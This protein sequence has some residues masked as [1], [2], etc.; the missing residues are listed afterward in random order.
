VIGKGP[1]NQAWLCCLN[2]VADLQ[3]TQHLPPEPDGAG[4][5]VNRFE[6]PAAGVL[7]QEQLHRAPRDTSAACVHPSPWRDLK[8][9]QAAFE[10]ASAPQ[11]QRRGRSLVFG[12]S[13]GKPDDLAGPKKEAPRFVWVVSKFHPQ[14]TIRSDRLQQGCLRQC[15]G[16]TTEE[17]RG[18][19]LADP[20]RSRT[21]FAERGLP[22]DAHVSK[23][24]PETSLDLFERR[25]VLGQR[26]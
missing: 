15:V 11:D 25:Q 3:G 13:I 26:L 20:R 7:P 5:I 17:E 16:M 14:D 21:R 1:R 8:R 10:H 6:L 18:I 9:G 22:I 23:F 4:I 12:T 24:A 19:S 2:Q